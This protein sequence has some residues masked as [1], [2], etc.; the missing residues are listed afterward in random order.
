MTEQEILN[1][2]LKDVAKGE[3]KKS[4]V[5]IGNLREVAKV[6]NGLLDGKLYKLIAKKYGE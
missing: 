2:F 3:G 5:S 4:Q 6:M 1:A